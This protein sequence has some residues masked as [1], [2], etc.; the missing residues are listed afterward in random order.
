MLVVA[1]LDGMPSFWG[2]VVL[3]HV[4]T[5]FSCDNRRMRSIPHLL[6]GAVLALR[7]IARNNLTAVPPMG[8][9]SWE[10]FRCNLGSPSDQCIDPNTTS[11]VSEA[12]YHG[13]ADAL[14][15]S[16]LASAGYASVHLDDC[17]QNESR[18]ANNELTWNASTFC[19]CCTLVVGHS[20]HPS[21]TARFPSGGAALGD[22]F[23]SRGLS[24]AFYTKFTTVQCPGAVTFPPTE[25]FEIIDAASFASW[26]IDYLKAD[27]CGGY[28]DIDYPRDYA[29]LGAAL[30]ATGRPIAYSCSWPAYMGDNEVS[31]NSGGSAAL[32]TVFCRFRVANRL[33]RSSMTVAISGATGMISNAAGTQYLL[34]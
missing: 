20:V 17:W 4:L 19:A 32:E 30:E 10:L 21:L 8:W 11:C 15:S 9:M 25:G 14:V 27:A 22:Y 7:A 16:G 1:S 13:I 34:S 5:H 3:L 23:H 2:P 31:V 33:V 29:A 6:L 18:N 12:L 24:F 28:G 26:G